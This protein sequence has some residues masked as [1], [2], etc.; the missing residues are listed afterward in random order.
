M[1]EP[2]DPPWDNARWFWQPVHKLFPGPECLVDVGSLD[3][4]YVACHVN[5]K[6]G[7][8]HRRTR[9]LCRRQRTPDHEWSDSDLETPPFRFTK[10]IARLSRKGSYGDGVLVPVHH[11]HLVEPAMRDGVH[12]SFRVPRNRS[13]SSSFSN[14]FPGGIRYAPQYAHAR[15]EVPPQGPLVNLNTLADPRVVVRK[16]GYRALNYV[17]FT[18]EGWVTV[19]SAALDHTTALKR[20]R[21][22]YSIVAPPDF[23]FACSQRQLE[24]WSFTLPKGFAELIWES[25]PTALSDQR[26]PANPHLPERPFD[27][28]DTTMTALVPLYT[29]D[30]SP[31][32]PCFAYTS[33]RYT[34]MP[35]D[36]AGT[37]GPGW[38]ITTDQ[39]GQVLHLASYGLGSPF[40]EDVKLCAALSAFWPAVSPDATR[41]FPPRAFS[42]NYYS[43]APMTDE[44]LGANGAKAWDGLRGPRRVLR[45]GADWVDVASF[46]HADY[47]L[48]ATHSGFCY[49]PT[50]HIDEKRY[51]LR[52]LAM[53]LVWQALG[54]TSRIKRSQMMVVS[55]RHIPSNDAELLAA[56][57]RTGITMPN[58]VF[59]FEIGRGGVNV[60]HPKQHRRRLV[61]LHE[62]QV[63]LVDPESRLVFYR[64]V[65]QASWKSVMI[66]R[67]AQF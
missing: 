59:R 3:L 9:N 12:V 65:S 48:T 10:S 50:L 56:Q 66:R 46:Q 29:S 64:K 39:T 20:A 45:H 35:D 54:F 60:P 51:S 23:F 41:T 18:G 42:K 58:D 43:V 57:R 8:L 62:R 16:G 34:H 55:F 37:F 25:P 1:F 2:A 4:E 11:K 30:V 53:A 47:T 32:T 44:E 27:L 26:Y 15:T 22:A 36:G 17:D 19:E 31:P 28:S 67:L 5:E 7:R 61:R 21:P 52:V 24:E 38:D 6:V 13:I 33:Q 14:E 63:V 40:T 49:A